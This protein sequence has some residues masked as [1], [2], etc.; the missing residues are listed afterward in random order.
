[1]DGRDSFS[2][3]V[4]YKG[5]N[6]Q[7]YR[8]PWWLPGGN[9]QTL[10]ARWLGK[11]YGL[12]YRR[13]RWETSDG[14]FIDLDWLDHAQGSRLMVLFHGLEGFSRSHYALSLMTVAAREG[15]R[16]VVPHFRGCSGE[17]NRLLQS[18]HS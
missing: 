10:Y 1:M 5:S 6:A 15:W 2:K 9:L 17:L 13:E 16:G 3:S 18:Y 8:A 11:S 14:D 4:G 7:S 12:Q